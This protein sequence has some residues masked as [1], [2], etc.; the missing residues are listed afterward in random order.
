M[1]TTTSSF[2]LELWRIFS[3]GYFTS[4]VQSTSEENASVGYSYRSNYSHH[5]HDLLT[6]L[7]NQTVFYYPI[8]SIE[9]HFL[10]LNIPLHLHVCLELLCWTCMIFKM[11]I[12][13]QNLMPKYFLKDNNVFFVI[14]RVSVFMWIMSKRNSF[15]HAS[16]QHCKKSEWRIEVYRFHKL[17]QNKDVC[18]RIMNRHSLVLI[19]CI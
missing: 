17:Q 2:V 4:K 12:W 10:S 18:F 15:L 5:C 9:F 8:K 6:F 19:L 7:F 3:P 1:N 11:N 16:W 13:R 14:Q